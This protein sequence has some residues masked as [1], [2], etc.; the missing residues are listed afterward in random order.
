VHRDVVA[1]TGASAGVG[2]AIARA[3]AA[4]GASVGLIARDEQRLG[5]AAHEVEGLGAKAA[6]APADVAVHDDLALAADHIEQELGAIDA[7]VNVAMTSVFAPFMQVDPSEYA[8]VTDVTYHGY[9]YGTRVALDHMRPRNRGV[10]VQVGSALSYRA[11]PLQSAYC[12][13]KHAINGFT[14]SVR[15]EL[16]NEGSEV[17]LCVVQLP[18]VN[19]PQFDWVR[20][21]LPRRARPVAPVF[22]P[23]VAARAVVHVAEHPRRE[24]WVGASTMATILGNRL[25][26]ALLD[27]FLA[28]TGFDSQQTDEPESERGDNLYQPVRGDFD[29]HGRFDDSAHAH[30][31]A[32]WAALHKRSLVAGALVAA[33]LGLAR[34]GLHRR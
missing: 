16:L 24:L 8:R 20:S 21:R 6:I 9:V 33:G 1:V 10:V 14:Q 23:E 28:R 22:Q 18:A 15:T 2:R 5:D 31:P 34:V 4:R 7:W 13:A 3:F 17:Q 29:A 11:I 26:P 32:T 19:T 30:S 25:A 12:G 27:R